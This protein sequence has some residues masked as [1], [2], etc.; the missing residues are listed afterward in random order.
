M[1]LLNSRP[2]HFCAPYLPYLRKC[3]RASFFLS[4]GCNLPSSSTTILS[5]ALVFCYPSTC[6]GLRYGYCS[7]SL[8]VF[9][10]SIPGFRLSALRQIFPLLTL[11]HLCGFTYTDWLAFGT[12]ILFRPEP[13]HS[14][15]PLVITVLQ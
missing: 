2:S 11:K 14:V 10:G 9:P 6:V 3:S 1:F 12:Q 8:E 5:L 15:T 4:Y 13:L 7:T